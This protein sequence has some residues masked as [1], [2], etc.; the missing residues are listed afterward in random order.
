M[1]EEKK[2]KIFCIDDF[3]GIIDLMKEIYEPKGLIVIGTLNENEI[4]DIFNRENPQIILFE[5]FIWG[6]AIELLKT[7][8]QINPKVIRC[9]LTTIQ[10]PGFEERCFKDGYCDYYFYKPL[11]NGEG[12]RMEETILGLAK[13]FKEQEQ[14]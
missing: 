14:G 8:K 4:M 10:P 13:T 5:P 12:R 1:L 2:V 9:I 11:G 3:Q 6:P 7:M